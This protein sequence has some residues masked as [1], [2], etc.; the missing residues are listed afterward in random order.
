MLQSIEYQKVMS[1]VVYV[2]LPGPQEPTPGMTGGELLHGFLTE[3]H[4]THNQEFKNI[5]N[6]LCARWNVHYRDNR[7]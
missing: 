4:G 2:N 6:L 5:I 3:L 1:D 7:G